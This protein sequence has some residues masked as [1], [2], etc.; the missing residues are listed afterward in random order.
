MA[1]S[2]VG[3]NFNSHLDQTPHS[4]SHR[5]SSM[6]TPTTS[7][8]DIPPGAV[9][10]GDGHLMLSTTYGPLSHVQPSQ[11]RQPLPSRW[12]YCNQHPKEITPITNQ[13]HA[14]TPALRFQT[15]GSNTDT[16]VDRTWFERL[17]PKEWLPACLVDLY[18]SEVCNAYFEDGGLKR[19]AEVCLLPSQTFYNVQETKGKWVG[20]T[21]L[22]QWE[23]ALEHTHVVFPMN[24]H[25]NHWL[26]GVITYASD[27]LQEVNPDGPIRTALVILNS[28]KNHN[29]ANLE[30]RLRQ[31]IKLLAIGKPLRQEGVQRLRLFYPPVSAAVT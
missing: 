4:C 10:I 13:I 30:T 14:G 27:L 11:P 18:L 22:D 7:S 31:M 29:P 23:S 19:F 26:L 12:T 20:H 28:I 17:R 25:G 21:L 24:A 1:D 3:F 15:Y 8:T 2:T 16:P 9:D 5:Y 6:A